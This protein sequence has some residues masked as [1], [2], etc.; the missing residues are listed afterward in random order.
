M[1][2]FLII[3]LLQ[4]PKMSD[5]YCIKAIKKLPLSS[6]TIAEHEL[7]MYWQLVVLYRVHD[8]ELFS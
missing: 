2:F 1:Y 4:R 7:G 8:F 6:L 3:L 5:F